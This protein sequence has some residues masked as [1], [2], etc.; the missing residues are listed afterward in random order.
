MSMFYF[1]HSSPSHQNSPWAQMKNQATIS[2]RKY[3]LDSL[4]PID[5]SADA[6]FCMFLMDKQVC[7]NTAI[8]PPPGLEWLNANELNEWTG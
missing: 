8:Y 3:R 6:A 1:L 4:C 2:L 5:F 7:L